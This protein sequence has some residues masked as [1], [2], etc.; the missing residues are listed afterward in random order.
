MIA[1]GL[2]PAE[3]VIHRLSIHPDVLSLFALSLDWTRDIHERKHL[4]ARMKRDNNNNRKRTYWQMLT[5]S[6]DLNSDSEMTSL[7]E[8]DSDM[9]GPSLL[10]RYARRG[11]PHGVLVGMY[12]GDQLA[13][14]A[15]L[16]PHRRLL[17][18]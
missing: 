11:R 7:R 8:S 10:R 9:V 12:D 16:H 17:S 2:G 4:L 6:G 14:E 18:S 15:G 1:R 13:L 3:L 5:M